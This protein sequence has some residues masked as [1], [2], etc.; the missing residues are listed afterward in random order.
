[1]TRIDTNYSMRTAPE[2]WME[3]AEASEIIPDPTPLGRK[4]VMAEV[5]SREQPDMV[6]GTIF[7]G[8]V[9][10]VG[11]WLWYRYEVETLTQLA[12]LAPL[13]G[14][15]IAFAVRVASGP[16]HSDVRATLSA[17]LYLLM[18]LSVAYMIER[19]QFAQAWGSSTQFFNSNTAL[20]RNRISEPAT[21]SFWLLG[22]IGTIHL[23]YMLGRRR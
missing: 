23:S 21:I 22:L 1:M 10:L 4:R 11:G 13:L 8:I 18:V 20:L 2:S 6:S 7:G 5:P 16:N 15:A 19:T 9:A 12:W 3:A 17:V 14:V